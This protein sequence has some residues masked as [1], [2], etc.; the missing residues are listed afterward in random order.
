MATFNQAEVRLLLLDYD[1]CDPKK[2]SGRKL[3]RHSL[4][5]VLPGYNKIPYN[6]IILSPFSGKAL[7]PPD[8]TYAEKGGIVAID[9]S[10][11]KAD[12]CKRCIPDKFRASKGHSRALPYLVAANPVNYGKPFMLSTAEAFAASLVIIGRE[13]QARAVM[14]VFK[15]GG[16]FFDM[17]REPMSEYKKAGDSREIVEMQKLFIPD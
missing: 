13:E 6:S 7:S 14:S 9:C 3:A 4:A 8:A 11:K 15:W 10:W 16:T 5:R 1:E 2:C 12:V 17:N